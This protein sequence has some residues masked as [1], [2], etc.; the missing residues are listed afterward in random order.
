MKSSCQKQE[1]NNNKKIHSLKSLSYAQMK[2]KRIIHPGELNK[3]KQ[4]KKNL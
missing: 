4:L 2:I 3:Y 1:N